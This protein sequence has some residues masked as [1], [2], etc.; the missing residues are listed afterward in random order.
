MYN[1][2][3]V[4]N[5]I[6]KESM[7]LIA[8]QYK[9]KI[10]EYVKKNAGCS[11]KD[12]SQ[13]ISNTLSYSSICKLLKSNGISHKRISTRIVCKDLT[14]IEESRK[15]FVKDL[16]YNIH[17]AIYIDET[18][19]KISDI[20]RYGYTIKGEEINKTVMGGALKVANIISN[21]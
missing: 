13:S 12:I 18:A 6:Q 15:I 21:R 1:V 16:N 8:K 11:L 20:K 2:D 7:L 19:F 14:Q 10:I 17:D 3:T 5:V 4:N 9:S